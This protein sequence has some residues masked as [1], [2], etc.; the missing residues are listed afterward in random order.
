VKHPAVPAQ[1]A[2]R[3]RHVEARARDEARELLLLRVK[4][5]LLELRCLGVAVVRTAELNK[6][7]LPL[8]LIALGVVRVGWRDALDPSPASPPAPLRASHSR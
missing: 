5:L 2:A 7:V 6:Y 8:W 4:R 1:H 3:E